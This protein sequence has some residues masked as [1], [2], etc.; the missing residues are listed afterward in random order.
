MFSYPIKR[1]KY[2]FPNLPEHF[3][4]N[5][6]AAVVIIPE[7]RRTDILFKGPLQRLFL[8]VHTY[9]KK[10]LVLIRRAGDFL[11]DQWP[12]SLSISMDP[13]RIAPA[14][15]HCPWRI[16]PTAFGK[17]DFKNHID[18]LGPIGAPKGRRAKCKLSPL[19]AFFSKP[20][21]GWVKNVELWVLDMLLTW[22]KSQ[23]VFWPSVI[24]PLDR[25]LQASK[26]RN[27]LAWK[28]CFSVS[29]RECTA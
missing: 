24:R 8:F 18:S 27:F 11:L 10:K 7:D 21:L 3:H 5:L 2:V 4:K 9:F 15:A 13:R 6:H 22:I 19:S 23:N 20:F 25:E 28:D 17:W 29:H 1:I 12:G 14:T 16:C 26:V